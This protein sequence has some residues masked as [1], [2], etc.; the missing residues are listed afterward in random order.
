MRDDWFEKLMTAFDR[1]V[2]E[3]RA[4]SEVFAVI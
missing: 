3:H 4:F 2:A 1:I